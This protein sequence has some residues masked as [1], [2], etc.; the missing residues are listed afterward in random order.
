M[1]ENPPSNAW[2]TGSIPGLGTE[3]PHAAG[4]TSPRAA[5]REA[6][7]SQL[8]SLPALD[9]MLYKSFTTSRKSPHDTVT[10]PCSQKNFF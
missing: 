1:V 2:G 9:P 10:I 7:G 3:I 4:L 6:S 8:R 5:T